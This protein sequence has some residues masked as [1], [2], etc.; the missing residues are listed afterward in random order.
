MVEP[1]AVTRRV[2]HMD[3]EVVRSDRGGDTNLPPQ[4]PKSEAERVF[5]LTTVTERDEL[6]PEVQSPLIQPHSF[7]TISHWPREPMMLQQARTHKSH[8]NHN[9]I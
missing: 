4:P 5:L 7:L 3:Y 9:N 8:H 2:G 6:G 1:L